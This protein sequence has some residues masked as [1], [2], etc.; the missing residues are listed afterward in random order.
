[1][2]AVQFHTTGTPDVLH[3]EDI[4]QPEPDEGQVRIRVAGSAVSPADNGIRSGTLPIPIT[5][6]HIP[7]YDVSGMIDAVGAG[8][9]LTVGDSVIGF[10][11]MTE[12]G[13]AAEFATA[14]AEVLVTAPTSM[15]LADAAAL[16]SV[17]LTAQQATCRRSIRKL[18]TARSGARLS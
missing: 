14:P 6:P 12:N 13:S 10:L 2:K 17:A 5:L 9:S 1:M 3:L 16:P 15:P 8:V 18:W 11:P 4:D 7:G